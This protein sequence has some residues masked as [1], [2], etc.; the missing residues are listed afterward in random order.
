MQIF[1]ISQTA[2]ENSVESVEKSAKQVKKTCKTVSVENRI[3]SG[4]KPA[5]KNDAASLIGENGG[6]GRRPDYPIIG[7]RRAPEN[8]DAV[9]N[10][11]SFLL[12]LFKI[13]SQPAGFINKIIRSKIYIH[14]IWD[15][16]ST[17][18]PQWGK[19]AQGGV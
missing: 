19:V 15:E 7:K 16:N 8:T 14:M 6:L 17:V 12:L 4:N 5:A 13:L 18:F 9:E 1:N 3:A 11:G 10:K 2:V